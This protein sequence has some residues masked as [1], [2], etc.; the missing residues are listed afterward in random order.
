M[1]ENERREKIE[2]EE[3]E[4]GQEDKERHL[5]RVRSDRQREMDRAV[6]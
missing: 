1:A 2:E 3:E 4:A 5:S 6:I